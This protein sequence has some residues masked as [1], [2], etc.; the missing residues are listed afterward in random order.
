MKNCYVHKEQ[1][2]SER[3]SVETD[4]Q[5]P[6]GTVITSGGSSNGSSD[7]GAITFS[8]YDIIGG[9]PARLSCAYLGY[10]EAQYARC[11]TV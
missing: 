2:K 3:I 10:H 1:N 5:T 11:S 7:T 9:Q 8:G 6:G 4:G